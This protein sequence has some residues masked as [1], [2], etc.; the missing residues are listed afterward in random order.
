MCAVAHEEDGRRLPGQLVQRGDE[1]VGGGES[2]PAVDLCGALVELCQ[3]VGVVRRQPLKAPVGVVRQEAVVGGQ[4]D[5]PIAALAGDA[6]DGGI[7]G[8]VVLLGA[9][10]SPVAALAVAVGVGVGDGQVR[11]QHVGDVL[12]ERDRA[13]QPDGGGHR[14]DTATPFAKGLDRFDEAERTGR[15]QQHAQRR[16]QAKRQQCGARQCG[17]HR[18]QGPQV[19]GQHADGQGAGWRR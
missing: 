13:G 17:Q 14:N 10:R 18:Q 2:R 6:P 15:H 19:D 9:G 5:G 11:P 1:L 12:A 4:H 7:D 8:W 3:R 16:L